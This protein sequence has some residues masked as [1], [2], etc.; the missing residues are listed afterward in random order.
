M[1]DAKTLEI[2][3][4][5]LARNKDLGEWRRLILARARAEAD[6]IKPGF[7]FDENDKVEVEVIFYLREPECEESCWPDI[8]NLAKELLDALQGLKLGEG[9]KS[10]DKQNR[11]LRTDICVYRLVA[12]KHHGED[13]KNRGGRVRVR[14][15]RRR[16]WT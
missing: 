6:R 3:L 15:Y 1:T 7:F 5:P 9:M 16:E 2:A 4:P 11:V 8:D 14:P 12:E 13:W 10:R